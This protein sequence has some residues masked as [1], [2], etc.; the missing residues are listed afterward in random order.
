MGI[1][2]RIHRGVYHHRLKLTDICRYFK[3]ST[4]SIYH[5]ERNKS[6]LLA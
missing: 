1:D 6:R 5:I 4:N 2:L 3:I